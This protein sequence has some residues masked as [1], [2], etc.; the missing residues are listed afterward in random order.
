MHHGRQEGR[1]QAYR[2]WIEGMVV[3][4]VVGPTANRGVD[5]RKGVVGGTSI[6]RRR[7]AVTV[8]EAGKGG[9]VDP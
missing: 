5:R 4:D 8:E 2:G 9:G 7:A 6:G 3:N 1:G